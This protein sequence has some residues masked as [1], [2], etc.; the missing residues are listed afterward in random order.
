MAFFE[1]IE[2]LA[3][4]YEIFIFDTNVTTLPYPSH[5][6]YYIE[7][8]YLYQ[9]N[10]IVECDH[11]PY[12]L[13]PR[14]LIVIMPKSVHSIYA[15]NTEHIQYG[16]IKFNPN[17]LHFSNESAPLVHS[18]FCCTTFQKKLPIHLNKKILTPYP[19]KN[20]ID[21]LIHELAHKEL[22]HDDLI[23]ALLRVL[24]V[25][26]MR[27]WQ[28]SGIDL[29]SASGQ[30]AAHPQ[31]HYALEYISN[32][33]G[34]PISIPDLARHC[35]MSYSTFSRHF[36]QQTGRSCKEYI[37]YVRVCKAQDLLLFTD[38]SLN[39]IAAETGFADCSHFI[40]TYKKFLGITPAQQRKSLSSKR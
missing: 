17:K 25:L 23:D 37:E 13:H 36:K 9:G 29:K 10:I 11:V 33:S 31:I 35:N 12:V 34:E 3:T 15:K 21:Q 7:L 28:N 16:V 14:D 38:Q 26:I 1:N 18:V 20:I 30:K 8:L 39:Y 2:T 32:H 19:V 24:L 27:I 6:H 4:P 5:W 22:F 40:K